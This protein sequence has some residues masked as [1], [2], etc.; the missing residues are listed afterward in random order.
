MANVRFGVDI[1]D[2]SGNADFSFG[3]G[4]KGSGLGMEE[5]KASEVFESLHT[6][7]VLFI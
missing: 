6:M 5:R 1:E 7:K 3:G 4:E 2:G